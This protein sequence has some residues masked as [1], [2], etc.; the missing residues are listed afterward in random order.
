MAASAVRM[1][2]IIGPNL[3]VVKFFLYASGHVLLH[4]GDRLV[5]IGVRV[6]EV[7]RE[8]EPGAILSASSGAADAILL[9]ERGRQLA[10]VQI[11][12]LEREYRHPTRRIEARPDFHAVDLL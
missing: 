11:P 6:V 12:G 3:F 8:A 9:V 2:A 10:H 1:A 7:R 4:R 5:D